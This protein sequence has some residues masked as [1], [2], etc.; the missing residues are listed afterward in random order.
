MGAVGT[1][2][3]RAHRLRAPMRTGR[4]LLWSAGVAMGLAAEWVAF[5]WQDPGHWIPDLVTGWTWIAFGLGLWS[6]RPRRGVGA[7]MAATGFTWFLGNFSAVG[8]GAVAWFG[9][10]A[11]Y[12]HRGPLV[13]LLVGYP[14]ARRVG[15]VARVT[16]A[17]GYVAA[18][19]TPVWQGAA[20]TAVLATLVLAV[21]ARAYSGS[22]G[23]ARRARGIA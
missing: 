2:D 11:V 18:V 7:L 4:A 5:G 10:H 12:L 3:R 13:H 15:L 20:A 17:V 21:T 23:G 1:R 6:A 19:A 22:V 16:V 14:S 9:T 8:V